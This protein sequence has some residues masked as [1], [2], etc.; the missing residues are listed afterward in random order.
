[1]ECAFFSERCEINECIKP[2]SFSRDVPFLRFFAIIVG[3]HPSR[4]DPL[5]PLHEMDVIYVPQMLELFSAYLEWWC[6][7]SH[8][9]HTNS[10]LVHL[11]YLC[12]EW[13]SIAAG[14][15]MQDTANTQ[16][17]ENPMMLPL[18]KPRGTTFQRRPH[19]FCRGLAIVAHGV[20]LRKHLFI[21]VILARIS[22]CGQLL[23]SS[24]A[25]AGPSPGSSGRT[26]RGPTA[27][28]TRCTSS[29]PSRFHRTCRD[30]AP[31]A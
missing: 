14:I 30:R 13:M 22:R 9:T 11:D 31:Q 18:R 10:S 21:Y 3:L 2:G 27:R 24:R 5:S 16:I 8:D 6:V 23:T 12:E 7:G 20:T 26:R 28:A 15:E 4:K 1:M 17:N 29:H 25:F 19:P